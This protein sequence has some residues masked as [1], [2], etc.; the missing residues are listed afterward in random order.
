MRLRSVRIRRGLAIVAGGAAIVGLL[1]SFSVAG[2]ASGKK[3]E[4]T[5]DLSKCE[6]QAPNL[7]KCPAVDKPI[8]TKDFQQPNVECIHVGKK[9]NI[10][11]MTPGG[12]TD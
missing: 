8:C 6:Q 2:A 3:I 4:L 5:F 1:G 12:T 7:Y 10:F 9:G 11:V